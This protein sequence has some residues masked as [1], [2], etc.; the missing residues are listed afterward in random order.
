MKDFLLDDFCDEG[1]SLTELK[2]LLDKIEKQ[3]AF[4]KVNSKDIQLLSYFD[5]NEEKLFFYKFNP[6]DKFGTARSV[7]LS[8]SQIL[9]KGD[10]GKYITEIEQDSK[11]MFYDGY[12]SYLVSNTFTKTL[13]AF[14]LKGAFLSEPCHERDQMIA[15][16]FGIARECTIVMK[17]DKGTRKAFAVLGN[18]YTH[19]PQS[20]L[21]DIVQQLKDTGIMGTPTCRRWEVNHFYT[22][23]YIEFPDKAEEFQI[24]YGLEKKFVP[25]LLLTTSDTGDS[26]LSIRSTWRI[27]NSVSLHREIKHK[28]MGKVNPKDILEEC[29][30]T[31]FSEYTK[32]PE[33]LCD[34]MSVDITNS[35]WDLTKKKGLRANEEAIRNTIKS[36]FKQLG[37]VKAIGKKAEMSLYEQLCGEFDPA[38][39]F[40]AYDI[41]VTL[42][43]MGDRVEG[44][45]KTAQ[46]ELSK[47]M[48]KAPYISYSPEPTITL[49]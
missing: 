28:H 30:K 48:A 23:I 4:L 1:T 47:A 17:N 33:A 22:S 45:S 15:K 32:L 16:R 34:L 3:T 26:S 40:T 44:L 43:G 29:E 20:I 18:K 24:L 13:D 39:S 25:G 38:I 19:I 37:V 41:A 5:S 2:N 21:L 6:Q 46:S 10:F 8:K 12:K 31:I 36:A 7:S 9:N 35:T 11:L 42:L 49:I 27:N 14:G